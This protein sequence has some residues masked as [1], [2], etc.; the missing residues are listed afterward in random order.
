MG[1]NEGRATR[2]LMVFYCA[3]F[4]F[5][6]AFVYNFISR[7][8]YIYFWDYANYWEKYQQLGDVML[9]S[10]GQAFAAVWQSLRHED[11]NLLPVLF[12]MPFRILF[13]DSRLA[14]ILAIANV[15][16]FPS[17]I[18]CS[19]LVARVL[20]PGGRKGFL[21]P[22]M[23]LLAFLLLPQ[24]WVPVLFGYPDIAGV[25]VILLILSQLAAVPFETMRLGALLR[26]GL[27]LCILVLLRR[28][29]A[30]WAV[31]FFIALAAERSAALY[32]RQGFDVR[33]YIPAARKG[34]LVGAVSLALFFLLAGPQAVTMIRT[35]Y[36]DIYSAYKTSR[37]LGEVAR[38]LYD[39]AGALLSVSLVLG[40]TAGMIREHTRPLFIFLAVQSVTVILLFARVQDFNTHHF[41]LLII[42]M[43][44]SVAMLLSAVL[45]RI[46]YI[47][48][49]I[50][51]LAGFS[52]V[53]TVQFVAVF[54]P[55]VA[56]RYHA[57]GVLMSTFRHYPMVR[58]D[59]AEMHRLLDTVRKGSD[60]GEEGI[61]VVA[62][63]T[64]LSDDILK[65]ACRAFQYPARFCGRISHASHVD[66]R[67]GFPEEF[68]SARYVLVAEPV[69]YHLAPESQRV[70]GILA[71][72][73][74]G[75]KGIG[76]SFDRLPDA[77]T[78][79]NNVH[80]HIYRKREPFAGGALRDLERRFLEYYPDRKDIFAIRPR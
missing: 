37:S 48:G 50:L 23:G 54:V 65:N 19:V 24:V 25:V 75:G 12:L 33:K 40:M 56:A 55:D 1:N 28:W 2:G 22:A 8:R 69:Q 62:S 20:S 3:A 27:L 29:Y 21:Y 46:K 4:V 60:E 80:V 61:Y 9:H 32:R 5:V 35:N 47:P 39:Y 53:M 70:V 77:F 41:Y 51:V 36:A 26:L 73:V 78:L 67:D 79:D 18:L 7:E 10:P 43:A 44:L 14:Y 58:N 11:Y 63:S 13:G 42:P 17:A 64:I 45:E 76:A 71:D 31:S 16:V 68:L 34:I 74:A 38:T 52:M 59:L 6:N 30:Y 66:K 49:R 15:Y 57:A 72:E